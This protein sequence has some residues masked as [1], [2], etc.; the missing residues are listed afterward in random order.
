MIKSILRK[1]AMFVPKMKMRRGQCLVGYGR[2]LG[3][4]RSRALKIARRMD[5]PMDVSQNKKKSAD[6]R[7]K[8]KKFPRPPRWLSGC[9]S[10]ERRCLV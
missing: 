9:V 6:Q 1:V 4:T 3:L 7:R 5:T 8:S 2:N 10:R